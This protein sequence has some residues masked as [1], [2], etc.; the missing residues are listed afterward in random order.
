MWYGTGLIGQDHIR[1]IPRGQHRRY[2]L[3]EPCTIECGMPQGSVLAWPSTLFDLYETSRQYH[4][5][6][7]IVWIMTSTQMTHSLSLPSQSRLW[8]MER[9]TCMVQ[10]GVRDICIW[11]SN[12]FLKSE[13]LHG[14]GL[15]AAA[16]QLRPRSLV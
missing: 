11:M 12:H 6:S 7:Y 3:S 4:L 10:L 15:Q 14:H 1:P 16:S 13:V 2:T 5:Q 9:C 8:W